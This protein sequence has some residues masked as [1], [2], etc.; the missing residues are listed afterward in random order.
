MQSLAKDVKLYKSTSA[1]G[2]LFKYEVM[3]TRK[4]KLMFTADFNGSINLRVKG[5]ERDRVVTVTAKSGE[6]TTVSIV[7]V[8]IP[9]DAW[10]LKVKYSWE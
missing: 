2:N 6:K 5:G 7:N 10:S 8:V 4:G 3:H 1:S 9:N